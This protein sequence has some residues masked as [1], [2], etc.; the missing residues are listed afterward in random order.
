VPVSRVACANNGIVRSSSPNAAAGHRMS[1][2]IFLLPH[3]SKRGRILHLF[4]CSAAVFAF[5]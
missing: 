2:A 1:F 3:A 4:K 5:G